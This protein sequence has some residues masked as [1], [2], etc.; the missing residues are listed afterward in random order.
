V[1]PSSPPPFNCPAAIF[2]EVDCGAPDCGC[3]HLAARQVISPD[4]PSQEDLAQAISF[5]EKAR[6]TKG[7]MQALAERYFQ[8]TRQLRE[9]REAMT[10]LNLPH[11]C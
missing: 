4:I 10:S 9:L 6:I 1:A 8:A 5:V 3:P 11:G 7:S 2:D